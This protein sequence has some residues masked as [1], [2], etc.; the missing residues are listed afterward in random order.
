MIKKLAATAMAIFTYQSAMQA[1]PDLPETVTLF[2]N[3]KVFNGIEDKLHDVDVLVVKNMIHKVAKDIPTTGTWEIDVQTGGVRQIKEPSGGMDAYSFTTF[4]QGKTEKK[5]VKVN[6]IAG[7]GRT[8]MPGLIDSHVHTNLYKD[9]T[10]PEF[11]NTTWEEI[12][13]RAVSMVQE[14]LAMGFTTLRDMCGAHEGL[15][16][17]IDQGLL[18]GPRLYLSGAC[19]SQTS[20]HGDFGIAGQRKGESNLERLEMTRLADGRDEVLAAG[21]RNFAL[22]AHY[23]KVMVSGG[24]TSIKDPIYA[25]Q[26][27]DDEIRAAV[28]TA[29]DWGTYVAVHVF[30]D[31]DIGR[32]LDLGVKCI[33]HG[34]PISEKNMKKLIEKDAFF[35]P[36]LVALAPEALAH[37]MHQDPDFPPTK[38]FMWL[39]DNS[40]NLIDLIKKYKPKMVFDSDYVLLTGVPYRLSMDFTKFVFAR[41]FGNF[42]ALQMMTSNGGELAELTGPENPYQEGKLGVIE[43][44]AY[45]DILIVDGNPL[46]DIS[47]IGAN[48]RW[49]DAEPRSKDVPSIRL[50]MKDGMIYK[51][52]L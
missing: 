6:V 7:D 22:G 26:Y 21:R 33:D 13:A 12:G 15:K 50:I 5:Q 9:G 38:K 17:V 29:E 25:S 28:E 49:F 52:T 4:E 43:E 51:N 41:E 36:N 45:A 31:D 34:L 8:L 37:P 40:S 27:S 11:Q 3:V 47:A 14:M 16:T 20:G 44:G 48:D 10:L 35:S 42:W 1:A 32:A 2:K 18:D 46:E 23:L 30:Q 19:I 39:R 24:V